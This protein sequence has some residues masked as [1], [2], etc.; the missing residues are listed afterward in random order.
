MHSSSRN[1]SECGNKLKLKYL[2]IAGGTS[3]TIGHHNTQEFW[4]S[5]NR[6]F[7]K[8]TKEGCVL[9]TFFLVLVI[10]P[11][12]YLIKTML[13]NHTEKEKTASLNNRWQIN[14]LNRWSI[15]PHRHPVKNWQGCIQWGGHKSQNPK[16][17]LANTLT[18]KVEKQNISAKSRHTHTI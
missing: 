13:Q 1:K 5:E 9:H 3:K 10:V 12:C 18:P 2:S 14:T 16:E 7:T 8:V 17:L 6:N 11:N 15:H 4:C